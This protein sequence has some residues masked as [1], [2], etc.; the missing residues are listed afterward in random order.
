[1]DLLVAITVSVHK[2]PTICLAS[3][4]KKKRKKKEVW[5][6]PISAHQHAYVASVVLFYS[7]ISAVNSMFELAVERYIDERCIF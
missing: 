1:M 6:T 5:K 7:P 2:H 3:I 4:L